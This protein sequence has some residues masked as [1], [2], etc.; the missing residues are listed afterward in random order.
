MKNHKKTISYSLLV[1]LVYHTPAMAVFE[2]AG[3]DTLEA[4]IPIIKTG[5]AQLDKTGGIL[6]AGMKEFGAGAV[7]KLGPIAAEQMDK[8]TEIAGKLVVASGTLAL[9]AESAS[10]NFGANFG[11]GALQQ[12]GN[13]YTAVTVLAAAHPIVTTIIVGTVVI[14]I[15]S[16][17]AYTGI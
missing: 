13:G 10:A 17:G 8:L 3:K 1:L 11:V 12:I 5:Y 2:K 15:V 16:Y 7:D 4:A 14:V 6:A 9:S